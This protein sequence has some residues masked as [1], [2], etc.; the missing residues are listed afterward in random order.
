MS[1]TNRQLKLGAFF[2][3]PGH[4]VAAWRYPDSSAD[5][6]LKFNFYKNLAQTAERGKFDMI[7]LADGYAAGKNSVSGVGQTVTVRPEPFTLLSALSAVTEKVGLAATVSTTYNEPFHVARKFASLDHLSEGRAGWNVVTSS[8]QAEALNFSSEDH[9]LHDL[10]YERAAEFVEVVKKLWDSWEDDA[11][12]INKESGVFADNDK[13]H[14]VNHE[15]NWFSVKGPLNIARPPQGHPVV[16]Q[17]GSSES[18][19]ELAAQTAEVIFTAWQTLEEA[20][21][22]Y[23]D[24]KGRLANYGRSHDELKIMPGIFPIIGRTEEEANE[25]KALLEELIPPAAGVGLL[26]AMIGVDLSQYPLDGPLPELPD[27]DQ[28]NG[29]K[30]RFQL[31]RDLAERENLTIRQLYQRI[32]GARGHKEIKGTP[33]QI[34][35]QLQEWFEHDAADGFNIMPPYLPGGLEDFVDLVIPELQRRGLFR[36]EYEG[37][38]LRENLGLLR[39]VNQFSTVRG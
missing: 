20:Q 3:I 17:A 39:P 25:K 14:E 21:T 9:L 28:V 4:H 23:K 1:K 31:L 8:T 2:M 37:E 38:T 22:F 10:R 16:I 30:S 5:Q 29:G 13:V 18:G 6:V 11:L 7:F 27:I 26:S 19:R 24:V 12:V 35:D 15:G 32:A 34:A 33:T 36:E